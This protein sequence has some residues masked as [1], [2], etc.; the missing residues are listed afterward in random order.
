MV[1]AAE[2]SGSLNRTDVFGILND[3]DDSLITLCIA[4]NR[5]LLALA[6]IAAGDAKADL[7]LHLAQHIGE[8]VS[9]LGVGID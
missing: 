5:A 7:F 3:T 6:D 4:A 8:L 2:L 1:E 9:D